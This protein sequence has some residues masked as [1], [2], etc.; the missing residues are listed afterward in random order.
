MLESIDSNSVGGSD[1]WSILLN[2]GKSA[3]ASPGKTA[4]TRMSTGRNPSNDTSAGATSAPTPPI[5]MPT[6]NKTPNT[7]P[8]FRS[9]PSRWINVKP[10]TS[11][12]AFPI[13]T[14]SNAARTT[15]MLGKTPMMAIG[16]PHRTSAR[17]NGPAS[18]RRAVSTTAQVPPTM[19]PT[20]IVA[21]NHP[22]PL[23][24]RSTSSNETETRSTV[25]K[26]RTRSCATK[27]PTITAVSGFERSSWNPPS[28]S[29]TGRSRVRRT[30]FEGSTST[31]M[32]ATA[33]NPAADAAE[34]TATTSHGSVRSS[35]KAARAGPAKVARPSSVP[36]VTFIAT[37]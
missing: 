22:T 15:A 18:R 33:T 35:S 10:D 16:I 37:S 9:A 7:R 6:V 26:P 31:R 8:R 14:V 3:T 20:P 36:A 25:S 32:R 4:P 24:P 1:C 5:A 2:R 11:S 21:A 17:A 30:A 27:Q 29:S 34:A 23:L 28:N 19:P 13:P 12:I